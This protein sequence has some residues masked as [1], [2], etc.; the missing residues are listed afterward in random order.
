MTTSFSTLLSQTTDF[1]K[2]HVRTLAIGAAAIAVGLTVCQIVLQAQATGVAGEKLGDLD[3]IQQLTER[4]EEGDEAALQELMLQM[5]ALDEN[6]ELDP[7]KAENIAAVMLGE[8]APVFGLYSLLVSVLSMFGVAYYLVFAVNSTLT[9]QQAASQGLKKF[10]PLLGTSI[11]SFLRSFAWLPIPIVNFALAVYFGPR[12]AMSGVL[13]AKEELGV[14]K[15]V[16]ESYHRSKGH[17]WKLFSDLFV[18]AIILGIAMIVL[19]IAVSIVFA[20]SS[21]LT[22]LGVM[23]ISQ[24]AMAYAT[25]FAVKLTETI[26]SNPKIAGA[27]TPVESVPAQ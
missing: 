13:L 10:F 24:F 3:R 6:G 9:P 8:M 12:F 17:W 15:S 18:L 1:C 7:A 2:T 19:N 21:W 11:W 25:V 20:F 22:Q 27:P 23:F 5:G 14:V 26:V 16:S 4:A